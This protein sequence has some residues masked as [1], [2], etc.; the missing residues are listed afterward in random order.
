MLLT[1]HRLFP[2]SASA[3]HKVF[4]AS[5]LHSPGNTAQAGERSVVIVT[6]GGGTIRGAANIVKLILKEKK[7][8]KPF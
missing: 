2:N 7:K 6:A 5:C 1:D 4:S 8:F 3:K